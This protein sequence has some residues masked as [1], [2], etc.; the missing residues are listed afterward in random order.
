MSY[1]E[2]A[3]AQVLLNDSAVGVLI[4]ERVYP[5]VA[6]LGS[7]FPYLLYQR[8]SGTPEHDLSGPIALRTARVQITCDATTYNEAKALADTV[9]AA[10]DG[11]TG[12]LTVNG[13]TVYVRN[14]LLV[15]DRDGWQ[16]NQDGTDS[17]VRRV[18]ADYQI[19]WSQ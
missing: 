14:L 5:Q 15:T 6:P 17:P 2:A 19:W 1:P 3:I 13:E 10:L 12:T 9:A 16:D 7:P 4:G 11:Y 18:Q 8:I